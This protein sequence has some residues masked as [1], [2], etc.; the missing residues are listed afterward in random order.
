[1]TNYGDN[2]GET[3]L[4]RRILRGINT[5][6]LVLLNLLFLLIIAGLIILLIPEKDKKGSSSEILLIN[7]TGRLVVRYSQPPFLANLDA[8]EGRPPGETLLMDVLNALDYATVDPGIKAV[9]LD[10]SGLSLSGLAM[11]K[12]L[13]DKLLQFQ[14]AGK[15]I[16]GHAGYMTQEQFYLYSTTTN[17]YLDPLFSMEPLGI[18]S[19]RYYLGEALDEWG[20]TPNVYKAGNYKSYTDIFTEKGLS[21][22]SR[23]ELERWINGLWNLYVQDLSENLEVNQEELNL[24]IKNLPESLQESGGD[25]SDLILSQ[26]WA[27]GMKTFLEFQED[28]N[29]LDNLKRTDGSSLPFLL[30]LQKKA[31]RSRQAEIALV[32]LSGEIT[33]GEGDWG[34]IGSSSVIRTLEQIEGNP[35]IKGLILWLDT[36]GGSVDGAEEIRRRVHALS[37]EIPVA[38]VSAGVNASGGYWITTAADRHFGQLSSITG[39]IGVFSLNFS[40]EDLLEERFLI[41]KDGYYTTEMARGSNLGEVPSEEF[42]TIRQ[43][44]V[45][46][47]YNY[48]LNLVSESR[49]I[50]LERLKLLAEGRIWTGEEALKNGLM[51]ER[52][53]LEAAALWV[54]EQ[55][56]LKNS[57]WVYYQEDYRYTQSPLSNLNILLEKAF[58]AGIS[59]LTREGIWGRIPEYLSP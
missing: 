13:R 30:Y 6:R 5:V 39:S 25:W 32:P 12:P 17:L 10:L 48:F 55:A 27:S 8:M 47:V 19:S 29:R 54:K 20:I 24:W 42:S 38:V 14:G 45:D 16:Y 53:D 57:S 59:N 9:E 34:R 1:M 2:G 22:D 51:D 4:F 58:Q 15:D 35:G 44:E 23:K 33:Y 11:I 50:P 28:L 52:G 18:S 37:E 3:T 41:Q 49:N 31:E 46:F 21:E 40:S 43:S 26:G 56:S 7:P 36:P